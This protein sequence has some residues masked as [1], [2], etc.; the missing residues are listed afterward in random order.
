MV[1]KIEIVL[2]WAEVMIGGTVGIMRQ[3]KNLKDGREDRYGAPK[4]KGWTLHIDGA[5]GEQALAKHLK[6]Y[7]SG[8]LGNFRAADVGSL[9]VRTT[10]YHNGHLLLHDDDKDDDIF[11]LMTGLVPALRIRGWCFAKEGKMDDFKKDPLGGREAYFV[12]QEILRP[13]ATLKEH[14]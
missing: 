13:M 10:Q 5:C 7:W 9:Q 14:L 8:N 12:P 3:V 2:T 1:D 6:M 4:D 11:V